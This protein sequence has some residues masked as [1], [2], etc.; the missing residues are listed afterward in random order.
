MRIHLVCIDIQRDFMD[1]GALPVPGAIA[2]AERTAAMIRRLVDKIDDIHLTVDSHHKMDISHP[3]W[4][5]DEHGNRPE[6]LTGVVVEACVPEQR[7][8]E[9]RQL[10]RRGARRQPEGIGKIARES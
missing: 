4:W 6:P 1:D 7:D 8:G 3:M 2:D 10:D 5:V 9:G